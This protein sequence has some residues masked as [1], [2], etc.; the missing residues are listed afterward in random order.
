M[1]YVQ[2]TFTRK[3]IHTIMSFKLKHV[4]GLVIRV[5]QVYELAHDMGVATRDVLD[6]PLCFRFR[7]QGHRVHVIQCGC[8]RV[9]W[10]RR[11]A[12]TGV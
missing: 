3:Y 7:N 10:L 8:C 5:Q 11:G 2:S 1:T 12:G 9:L 6:G 4:N